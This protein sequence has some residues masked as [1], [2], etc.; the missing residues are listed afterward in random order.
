MQITINIPE[1]YDFPTADEC[2]MHMSDATSALERRLKPKVEHGLMK[3]DEADRKLH[4]YRSIA[5]VL[6]AVLSAM[7][8]SGQQRC[9]RKA[10]R[11]AQEAVDSLPPGVAKPSATGPTE[12]LVCL[13]C[14]RKSAAG[15][16]LDGRQCP[17]K[18][19]QADFYACP[20]CGGFNIQTQEPE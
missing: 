3:Q 15:N 19:L 11:E 13:K 20:D 9:E 17:V 2:A 14:G 12:P 4:L 16:F 7:D 6:D 8:E 18:A 5:L 1:A 10:A